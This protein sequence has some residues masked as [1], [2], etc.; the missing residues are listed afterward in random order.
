MKNSSF[1]FK[2]FEH[3]AIQ[4][5]ADIAVVCDDYSV[6]YVNLNRK[7]NKLS[8]YLIGA[9]IKQGDPVGLLLKH[10]LDI[11]V[12]MLSV[13]K[14]G[15]YYIPLSIDFPPEKIINIL[16]DCGCNHI[17]TNVKTS[18]DQHYQLI[19]IN[20]SKLTCNQ[21]DENPELKIEISELA[22]ILFTSGSTGKPKGVKIEH[23]NLTYYI[24]WYLN[25]LQTQHNGQLPL[26]SSYIFAAS[27]TQ[28]YV[29]L[30]TGECL[31]VLQP[32]ISTNSNSLLRWYQDNP[33]FGLYIV[34]TLWEEHL[35]FA[36]ANSLQL[37][38]FLLLT[39]EQLKEKLVDDTFGYDTNIDI[40]NM[41]GPTETVAN[42]AYTKV[43]R[44][45]PIN[46]G[47]P[48]EGSEAI[49]LDGNQI[50][51]NGGIGELCVTGPGVTPGYLNNDSLNRQ[52]FVSINEKR[53]YRTGD[54][55]SFL[56]DGSLQFQGRKDRQVKVNGVRIELGEI[57]NALNSI[58]DVR[59]S[60]VLLNSSGDYNNKLYGYVLTSA[61]NSSLYYTERLKGKLAPQLI[62]A[63]IFTLSEF[64]KLDNGKTDVKILK[65]LKINS[66]AKSDFTD[67]SDTEKTIIKIL[68]EILEINEVDIHD[69]I[70]NIGARSITVI[71]LVNRLNIYFN[72][73]LK[74]IDIYENPEVKSL[75][76]LIDNISV[77]KHSISK[78]TAAYELAE[79][80]DF[81]SLTL[82]Q[83][84]LW[85]VDQTKEPGHA[86][87]IIFGIELDN[88]NFSA[89]RLQSALNV[90]TKKNDVLRSFFDNHEGNVVRKIITDYTPEIIQNSL[91]SSSQIEDIIRSHNINLL[92]DNNTPP[93][94][95]ILVST[96]ESFK[97]IV[98]INHVIFDGY[99]INLF[100]RKLIDEYIGTN[101]SQVSQGYRY[102]NF[103]KQQNEKIKNNYYN[104]GIE[105]WTQKLQANSYT[106]NLPF[107][108]VRPQK[109]SFAGETVETRITN[110][111][112]LK[113]QSFCTAND[114]SMFN[115]LLA[116]YSILLHKYCNQDDILISFPYANRDDFHFEEL[117]GYFVNVI[118]HRSVLKNEYSFL[119][120][121]KNCNESFIADSRHM[122][123][124]IELVYPNLNVTSDP[125]VNPLFQV[126]FAWHERLDNHKKIPELIYNVEEYT[127]NSSKLDLYLEAQDTE[128]DILLR[129][130]YNTSIFRKERIKRFSTDF[131]RI[132]DNILD[133]PI[134]KVN[135]FSLVNQEELNTLKKWNSTDHDYGKKLVFYDLFVDSVYKTPDNV[136]V[137]CDEKSYLYKDILK[138][139]VSFSEHL[140]SLG[141]SKHQLVG[142]SVK[143]GVEMLVSLIAIQKIGAAYVPLDP[144]YPFAKTDYII[145]HS[146]I[147][148]IIS[149][150]ENYQASDNVKVIGTNYSNKYHEQIH[151]S[152]LS[153]EDTMY[154]IYTS[155][156]TGK[157]KGV[158]VPNKGV[159]N[160]LLWMKDCFQIKENDIFLYQTSINFDISVWEMFLPL[161]SG[162]SV[163]ML[164]KEKRTS[165]DRILEIIDKFGITIIQF[166][167][168]ALQSFVQ[169]YNHEKLP[170][171]N[172]IF[173][174][175]ERLSNELNNDCLN[176]INAELINLYGPTEASIFCTYS[177]CTPESV[178][179]VSIGKPIYNATVHILDENFKNIPIGS[180]GEIY[181]SGE[182]LANGYINNEEETNAR[183]IRKDVHSKTMFRTGDIGSFREN[184]EIDFW[185]R[186]D[187]Q[188][189]VRGYR[190]ELSEIE[191]VLATLP[192]VENVCV[193]LKEIS[194]SDKRIIAYYTQNSTVSNGEK[195]RM[196]NHAV[197]FL[198]EYMIP[199]EFIKLDS[200]PTLP[201][202]KTDTLSL[203]KIEPE[204]SNT[205]VAE[206]LT[207]ELN[208]VEKKIVYIWE[209][210]LGN[211]G[212]DIEDNFFEVGG[213]S[214]LLLKIKDHFERK[215]DMEI[216]LTD[217]YK[218]TNIKSLAKKV[219]E[220]DDTT[221]T[222][223]HIRER[224]ANKK[225]MSRS[226]IMRN[227]KKKSK[228]I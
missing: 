202:G 83:K 88:I 39:G 207:S 180:K 185:G 98:I 22:Y 220:Q 222:V 208:G 166:V 158:V 100:T 140:S 34:P 37:P 116:S 146:G 40:W 90:V 101:D 21:S 176:N 97:F 2:R 159:A 192:E 94:R 200:F 224:I 144:A 36:Q 106:I 172:K 76:I 126:M 163:V 147:K 164:P 28:L 122:E 123:C 119:D 181:L 201:N 193:L 53:Y 91:S 58:D 74:L 170:T 111:Q 57:E 203:L 145:S 152:G 160:Y 225:R 9:G 171:L 142:V 14:T 18:L 15:G 31:N 71:K 168:S 77:H 24:D 56:H 223:N 194:S 103:Q 102:S 108:F 23:R 19:D 75:A 169:T 124:P 80:A 215:F 55:A 17:I 218:Y 79:E 7:A 110:D 117:L 210:V 216:P 128:K 89:D 16:E 177:H 137:I 150:D 135:Q 189:K 183:F 217:Y 174:G 95:Y 104:E 179:N 191:N 43:L 49:L 112:K 27:V 64:P 211:K 61:A 139:V 13:A 121:V 143:P 82:N 92:V 81:Y 209:E 134:D 196:R 167:P 11:P 10:N 62:P 148:F 115:F 198:P 226:S 188:V 12:A 221:D 161:I 44:D 99:S 125:S 5:P 129:F 54:L 84:T 47:K 114:V 228:K 212:F 205:D 72:R 69:N 42:I 8:H 219:M 120:M 109:Q 26:T 33:E 68:L 199:S 157:S 60:V 186:M 151:D 6:S 41:Y 105:Y 66:P 184:G 59:E 45:N 165:S 63:Y 131:L 29:P 32:E 138:K 182:I 85:L 86:Y 195:N 206:K 4:N 156:S 154:V 130:N 173:V 132:I 107:D 73:N 93:V 178:L 197:Q 78:S 70:F 113:I 127:N 227:I 3:F 204:R 48:L 65:Q 25:Y 38:K 155:G 46:I 162:A 141:V 52:Q 96:P 190:L 118:L 30:I 133:K 136:A 175:G 51:E 214:L 35:H 87:N 1:L 187:R 213:H 20:D 149:D 67:K 50:L 153:P